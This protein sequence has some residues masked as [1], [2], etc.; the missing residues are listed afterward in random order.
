MIHIY[1]G[2]GKGK[3]TA[4]LGLAL[5]AAGAGKKIHI[6]QFLKGRY[7]C[8]L[9]SLKRFKNIKVE[10]FGSGRF[11]KRP[12]ARKDIALARRGLRAVKKVLGSKRCDMIILDEI[13][14]A[15]DLGL[16]KI[17]ELLSLIKKIPKKTEVVLTGRN[18]PPELIKIADLVSDIK[19][20]K[21]YYKKGLKARKGIEF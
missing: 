15:L 4:A 6:C 8:E 17:K 12:P 16:L 18:A 14:S 9:A 2:K 3:T 21:H 19:E 1:T 13:N 7:T 11:V 10:R 20:V 5:R